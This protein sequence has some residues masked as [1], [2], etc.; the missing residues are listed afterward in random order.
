MARTGTLVF[1]ALLLSL[2]AAGLGGC[3]SVHED[4]ELQQ[5]LVPPGGGLG[6]RARGDAQAENYAAFGDTIYVN[7]DPA[8]LGLAATDEELS[9]L[10][11]A[12]TVAIDGT[13]WVPLVGRIPVEGLT[14]RQIE[15]LIEQKL[16]TYYKVKIDLSVRILNTGGK[17]FFVFGEVRRKGV[18]IFTKGD[19]TVLDVIAMVDP[20]PVANLGK[21][22][23]IRADPTHP[24]VIT[25][26]V[27]E[28]IQK[29]FS[30]YNINIK[31]DDIIY[32][33]PTFLGTVGNF[34][35]RLTY[36]FQSLFQTAF[37][38]VTLGW[39]YRWLKGDND[40]YYGGIF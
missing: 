9:L 2:P 13:I 26:N 24:L 29:G 21:V 6:R 22:K 32:V 39:S 31:E 28:I 14:E 33:P 7:L 16:S 34:L 36:P 8:M 35:S 10:N 25:V 5:L 19:M 15:S 11:Q 40:Y 3:S 4:M 27:R 20:T 1:Y 30:G 12:Q 18:Q 17:V 37:G 38:V 23:V